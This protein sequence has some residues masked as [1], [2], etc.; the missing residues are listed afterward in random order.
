M[1]K[2]NEPGRRGGKVVD[3]GST[4]RAAL[5][6]GTVTAVALTTSAC[7]AGGQSG[8][9][10]TA[11][12]KPVNGK[13]FT[14]A[15]ASDPGTLDPHMAV[16]AVA[17]QVDRY[18]YD[19]LLHL[20]PDGKPV[21]GLAEKWTATTDKAT[22]TLRSGITCAD[23]SPLTAKD[24]AANIN[25][26]GDPANNSPIAGVN[27]TPGTKATADDATR[28]VT[29]TSGAPDAFLLRNAG[30]LP[31]VCAAG[32]KDRSLLAKGGAGTGM[33]SLTD[34]VP[35]D[36]YTLTRR[37]DYTWGPGEWKKDQ[38]G[39]PER[40]II[41]VI[42][43][44]STASNLLLSGELNAA[45][46]YGPDKKRLSARKLF[47]IDYLSV[48]GEMF[49]NQAEGRVS[50]D[51]GVRRALVQ[52]LDLAKIGKVLT[53]GDGEPATGMVTAEPKSC[54]GDS[55]TGNLPAYDPAAA[56]SALDAAGWRTGPDGVRA[57]DGKRLALDVIYGSQFG[58]TAAPTAELVQK[59][60]K[61][62]GVDV[63]LK[64]ADSSS[65]SRALFDTG[66]WDVSMNPVGSALPSQVV[67]F[68]S[69]PKPPQGT[70][71]AHIDNATYEAKAREAMTKTGEASCPDWLAAETALVKEVDAVPYMNSV[72]SYFGN[73]ARF[74]LSQNSITP[75]S[76]RMYS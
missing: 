54:T 38:P 49:F 12:G 72:N 16:I 37:K 4:R 55:V 60:W 65:V 18:L 20:D 59:T 45:E 69:G 3:A 10:R 25:F 76:I 58:P 6:V 5:L 67:A 46:I 14:Q 64:S 11:N 43:N 21:A 2:L 62:I 75:T 17:L 50:A 7:S 33:F 1:S 73:G 36:H 52:S 19:P 63:A 53:G 48:M 35:N 22:F 24:V 34:A 39:L 29:L 30:S 51:G 71:F 13:T 27:I 74:E 32:L 57:R 66:D 61:D 47:H 44:A 28:T 70:N 42:P 41:R 68:L 26:V 40:A 31:I 56:K 8:Q 23:G 15:I 9:D